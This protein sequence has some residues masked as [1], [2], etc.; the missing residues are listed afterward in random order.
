MVDLLERS[1]PGGGAAI[2]RKVWWSLP[3]SVHDEAGKNELPELEAECE[4]YCWTQKLCCDDSPA[5]FFCKA[6]DGV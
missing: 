1:L 6:T 3:E 2:L 5:L 4:E